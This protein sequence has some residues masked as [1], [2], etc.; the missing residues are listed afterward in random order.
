MKLLSLSCLVIL[1]LNSISYSLFMFY[2]VLGM[3][4]PLLLFFYKFG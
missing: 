1:V 3:C 4:G 2:A